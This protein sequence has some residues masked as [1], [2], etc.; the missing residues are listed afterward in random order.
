M[1]NYRCKECHAICA[2]TNSNLTCMTCG[3]EQDVPV[4]EE[5]YG[6]MDRVC[7][8]ET[9]VKEEESIKRNV[10]NH[11]QYIQTLTNIPDDVLEVAKNM[12][13]DFLASSNK[14]LKREERK[15]EFCCAC[16]M[17]ATRTMNTGVLSQSKI[18]QKIFGGEKNNS[19]QWAC[20]DLQDI[21]G[22]HPNYKKLFLNMSGQNG[23]SYRDF[24]D[25]MVRQQANILCESSKENPQEVFK[26]IFKLVHKLVD[27]MEEKEKDYMKSTHPEKMIASLIFVA[28]KLLKKN[29]KLKNVS[30]LFF[31][32]EP[33]ILRIESRVLSIIK[34]K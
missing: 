8:Y 6:V 26:Q 29:V 19:I 3:L 17:Y 34:K 31:T 28:C 10:L 9:M 11:F 4:F 1:N 24:I 15:L 12:Y 18:T 32:S 25:K 5:E 14:G 23:R 16:V 20:K 13:K 22:N 27:I 2:F 33:L 30:T 21:L 7:F